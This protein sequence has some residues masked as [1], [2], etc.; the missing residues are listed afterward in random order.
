[1]AAVDISILIVSWNVRDLLL[2]C[3]A[4]LPAA[5]GSE[6]SYEIIVV[7]NASSDGTVQAVIQAFPEVHVIANKENRSFTSGNNQ[8]L[9]KAR[10]DYLFLLNPDAEP[11]PGSIAELWRYLEANPGVGIAGPR[12]RYP[13]GSVQSSRRRFPTLPV[14]FTESAVVQ[15]YLP[16][17]SLFR[18]YYLA[19]QADDIPQT[20]DWIVGA[21]MFARRQV[22]EQIGGLDESFFMYS[23]ELDWC[24][25]AVEAGW[26][27]GYVPAAGIVH[28][29]GKS[30]EQVMASRHVRFFSSRVLYTRKYYGSFWAETLRLW[31]L[32][33]FAFQW[34][35]EGAK[36]LVGHK[37]TLRME[38]MRAYAQV[39]RSG[40]RPSPTPP[41]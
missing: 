3:L 5:G 12:L 28:Y 1:M 14:L 37:R 20:V 10:G 15:E 35:R 2:K 31:L 25:R 9:A 23:E 32:A 36:W 16:G 24:R 21:A 33:I 41:R 34:L 40:L 18:R 30:S 13:D 6:R 26:Q 29:E 7:D 17:L 27:V 38:R 22:Y 11:D 4:A 39:L 19:D 8:A